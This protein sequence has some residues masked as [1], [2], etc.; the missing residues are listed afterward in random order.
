MCRTPFISASSLDESGRCG[1][2]M[3]GTRG[4]DAAYSFGAYEGRLRDLI[5]L[6]K[7]ARMRSLDKPLGRLLLRAV[8]R[9]E[10]FD[11]IIPVPMHWT[12]KWSRGFNQAESLAGVLSRSMG[13]PMSSRVLTRGRRTPSQAGLTHV[14]RR[15]NMA[16]VFRVAGEARTT[17]VKGRRILLVDDVFTTGATAG[18]CAKALKR[19]GARSVVLLTL[20]R[21]DRRWIE[22]SSGAKVPGA[23]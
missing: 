14:Q 1:F 13:L 23:S 19:A 5:H 7:Y 12:R 11:L 3:E 18:A 10:Q 16:G 20:A 15:E 22:T 8:P 9:E 6:L 2:C 4:F 17:R 21:V